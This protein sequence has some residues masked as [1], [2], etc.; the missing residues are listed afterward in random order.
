MKPAPFQYHDPRSV[1]E[2]VALLAQHENTKLLAGGQSLGPMLNFR[3]VMPDHLIDL[4]RISELAYIRAGTD[5]LDIGAMTRQRALER[6]AEIKRVCPI[7][8]EALAWVGHIPTRNRGTIGGSLAHLDPAAELPGICALYDATLTVAGP[9]GTR[10]VAMADW[11]VSFMTPNL[12]PNEVLTDITL[13]LWREPHGHAF[14][15]FARRHGD[16]AIAG[17]GCLVA[18]DRTGKARRVALSLI[19]VSSAPVRLAAAEKL[20]VGTDL[21]DKAIQAASAEVAKL[22]ALADAYVSAAYRK[23]VAGVLLGRAIK[24]AAGRAAQ[25]TKR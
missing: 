25:G 17:V 9:K 13:K 24:Q 18:L 21:S 1:K 22:E 15:E 16:F 4:N 5:T 8:T 11:G 14:V 23:R 7:M 6:A 2:A 12:E 10:R 20:L 3:F 19:G